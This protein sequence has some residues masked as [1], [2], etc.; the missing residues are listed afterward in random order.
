MSTISNTSNT[1]SLEKVW[2]ALEA[3][4]ALQDDR[5]TFGLDHVDIYVE[6]VEGNWLEQWGKDESIN[7]GHWLENIFAAD[8]QTVE[9]ILGMQEQNLALLVTTAGVKR[10]KLIDLGIRLDG[11]DVAL[12]VTIKPEEAQRIGI[13]IQ[14]YSLS[15]VTYLPE[16]LQL[17]LLSND[18][19]VISVVT[20]RIADNVIQLDFDGE[21]GEEFSVQVAWG[22]ISVTEDFVI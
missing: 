9:E 5:L 6:D 17:I 13:L 7:L 3:A 15:D 12:I 16:N 20:A 21:P 18:R 14:L 4:Q 19:Q 1:D 22:N 10:A 11:A 8:W 2:Q